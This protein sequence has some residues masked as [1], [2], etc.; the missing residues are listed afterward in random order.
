MAT[1]TGRGTGNRQNRLAGKS[2]KQRFGAAQAPANG[3]RVAAR[4]FIREQ[5]KEF[6][7]RVGVYPDALLRIRGADTLRDDA[8][9][10]LCKLGVGNLRLLCERS[11]VPNP[12]DSGE[13]ALAEILTSA[14][15]IPTVIHL[16]E[17]MRR[18][19]S[20]VE[21][22][23]GT[24][25]PDR[26]RQSLAHDLA[27]LSP[28]QSEVLKPFTKLLLLYRDQS[29]WL[30]EIYHQAEWY[31]RTSAFEY[32][33]ETHLSSKTAEVLTGHLDS[34]GKTIAGV[35]GKEIAP[36]DVHELLDDTVVCS[37]VR[38]YGKF[39]RPDFAETYSVHHGC[40]L[41]MFGMVPDHGSVVI[42]CA[43]QSIAT[44]LIVEL[45][46]LFNAE[47][48]LLKNDVFSAFTGDDL[49]QRF[50][51]GYPPEHGI[52][53]TEAVLQRSA[54]P[55]SPTL[56][57][58]AGQYQPGIREAL[59]TLRDQ[60]LSEIF[61]PGDIISITVSFR[62]QTARVHSETVKEGAVRFVFENGGWDPTMQS[63]F[64]EA[65]L[66]SFGV[67][68]NRL[69]DPAKTVL[70]TEGVFAHLLSISSENDVQTYEHDCFDILLERGLLIRKATHVRLCR[71]GIC[72]QYDRPVTDMTQ[73]VCRTC[74]NELADMSVK[75]IAR[76]EDGMAAA[77]GDLL[78]QSG[79]WTI[80]EQKELD[81][82][83]Y[84]PLTR[85]AVRGANDTVCV[86]FHDKLRPTSKL[87]FKRTGLPLLVIHGSRLGQRT[88]VDDE[89]IAHISLA[90]VMAAQRD[91]S[92]ATAC[93]DECSDVLNRL[94]MRHEDRI[95]QAAS[96]S[97][98]R[99]LCNLDDL[100]GD[101][102][103]DD[104]FN[105]LRSIFPYT[106]KLGQKAKVQ[107]D[108]YVCLP[109][110]ESNSLQS[111]GS[112]NWSYD[113]KLSNRKAGYQFKIDEHRKV[114]QYIR[115]LTR[116]RRA[117][118]GDKQRP[119]AHVLISNNLA[120]DKM[121][122]CA[123][124]V[125]GKDGVGQQGRDIRLVLIQQEFLI[126]LYEGLKQNT[127]AIRRRRPFLELHLIELL[128]A[129]PVCGFA[130]L[131]RR[132]AEDLLSAV[133]ACCEIEENVNA[134]ELVSSLSS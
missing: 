49:R 83:L 119:R 26:D 21:S 122:R 20:W 88:L 65:F 84:R 36:V 98:D 15:D 87:T 104:I 95:L 13:R 124:H 76:S 112:W 34:I 11:R 92:T 48:R 28:R 50:L 35:L 6:W 9:T 25:C 56:T 74:D 29:R 133:L 118:F 90:H 17:F 44:A 81:G 100:D 86:V 99:L 41:L 8:V 78:N 107:P 55:G 73:Q 47:F 24:A 117:L 116:N 115:M 52:E 22:V 80:G 63:E 89:G 97:H 67:P 72:N 123:E 62:G 5:P 23:F 121:K 66:E 110:Y 79:G 93:R 131:D 75:S 31:Q 132:K 18:R 85:A 43:N 128:E 57:L 2:A 40:G 111:V 12:K 61:G 70:G 33:T 68:L 101:G 114:V 108:G 46:R 54:F 91:P 77:V 120:A 130:V 64:E 127:D 51:G 38:E 60:R 42:K 106:Y 27:E 69:L 3:G 126:A 105:M 59:T 10:L 82:Q 14:A 45:G 19:T 58:T 39:I 96:L 7:H 129:T 109:N 103:E 4:D 16:R 30:N 1:R 94:L 71:N 32:R 134:A 113:A 125:F 102:Y 53:V 37:F